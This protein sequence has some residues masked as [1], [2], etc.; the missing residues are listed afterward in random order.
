MW[1]TYISGFGDIML[2]HPC[3]Y[4]FNKSSKECNQKYQRNNHN[5]HNDILMILIAF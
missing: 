5:G 4:N 2:N 1:I 3:N